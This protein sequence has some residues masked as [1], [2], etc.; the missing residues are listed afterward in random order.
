MCYSHDIVFT[1]CVIWCVTPWDCCIRIVRLINQLI[2]LLH[3]YQMTLP[4]FLT[5]KWNIKDQARN[6]KLLLHQ[7][8]AALDHQMTKINKKETA[9]GKPN[10]AF[11]AAY[12]HIFHMRL[13]MWKG[14]RSAWWTA[15]EWS[16]P[17]ARTAC[18]QILG[19]IEKWEI[20]FPA[21][22]SFHGSVYDRT[23]IY[24]AIMLC[25]T[26]IAFQL[27]L[28]GNTVQQAIY[29]I[30]MALLE[31][32]WKFYCNLGQLW[33]RSYNKDLRSLIVNIGLQF[34]L[35]N[36]NDGNTINLEYFI[37]KEDGMVL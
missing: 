12:I 20:L 17:V 26:N 29:C 9:A 8:G 34:I 1:H 6:V 35:V 31:P 33:S 23:Y 14:R 30:Y 2:K 16:T 13:C 3:S 28:L 11:A 25:S 10:G 24:R 5:K 32:I 7:T 22:L 18:D 36:V 19:Y 27:T 4:F 21:I 15:G 37:I